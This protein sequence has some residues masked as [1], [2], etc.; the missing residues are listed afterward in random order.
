MIDSKISKILKDKRFDVIKNKEKLIENLKNKTISTISEIKVAFW[1]IDKNCSEIEYEPSIEDSEETPEFRIVMNKLEFFV[2][3]KNLKLEE[4]EKIKD[5]MTFYTFGE[6]DWKR[7]YNILRKAKK[8]IKDS[9]FLVFIEINEDIKLEDTLMHIKEGE[10]SI[11][12]YVPKDKEKPFLHSKW[13]KSEKTLT[14]D[15]GRFDEIDVVYVFYDKI[16]EGKF[17]VGKK[18]EEKRKGLIKKILGDNEFNP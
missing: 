1:F 11:T 7:I 13:F 3:V 4:S 9:I 14:H 10:D 15:E 5:G 17:V 6:V 8:G 12:I 18:I 2:E 16:E